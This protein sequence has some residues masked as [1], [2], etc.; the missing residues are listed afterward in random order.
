VDIG[1]MSH[2]RRFQRQ[3]SPVPLA[4]GGGIDLMLDPTACRVQQDA[5]VFRTNSQSLARFIGVASLQGMKEHHRA[6]ARR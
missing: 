4:T 2:G 5:L 6:P 3:L 1:T